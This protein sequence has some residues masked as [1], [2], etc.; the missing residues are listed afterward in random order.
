MLG[1]TDK[2]NASK[3]K[4]MLPYEKFLIKAMSIGNMV[5]EDQLLFGEVQWLQ[6]RSNNF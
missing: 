3:T 6:V 2:P 5:P 4:K 1:I